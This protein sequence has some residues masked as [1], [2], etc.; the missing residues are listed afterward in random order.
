MGT[1]NLMIL[2]RR[3]LIELFLTIAP[4]LTPPLIAKQQLRQEITAN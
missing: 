2:A 1:V 3:G 4:Y